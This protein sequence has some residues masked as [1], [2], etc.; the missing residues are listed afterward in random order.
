MFGFGHN[1]LQKRPAV[2]YRPVI[3]P[4]A[5]TY[6]LPADDEIPLYLKDCYPLFSEPCCSNDQKPYYFKC[7]SWLFCTFFT[8]F[9]YEPQ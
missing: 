9:E 1:F 7:Y 4:V 3:L 6:L 8:L 2:V 5:L